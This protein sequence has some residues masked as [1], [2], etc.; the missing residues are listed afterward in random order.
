[1]SIKGKLI[2]VSVLIGLVL[3]VLAALML[4][5]SVRTA[6]QV[7]TAGVDL[8]ELEYLAKTRA[9][10]I[11][12]TKEAMDYLVSGEEQDRADFEAYG[13]GAK[14]SLKSWTEALQ[15]EGDRVHLRK[16]RD[17]EEKYAEFLGLFQ[18]AFAL[19]NAG[20]AAQAVEF[21]RGRAEP[22]LDNVLLERISA[23]MAWEI[24]E[25]GE[26][27]DRVLLKMGLMPWIAEKSRK[28][29][30]IARAAVNYFLVVDRARISITRQMQ[31]AMDYLASAEPQDKKKYEGYGQ[32]AKWSINEWIK[33]I[34]VQIEL[35][36]D[37]E[38]ERE[39][40][41]KVR[42]VDEDYR[43]LLEAVQQAFELREA[44]KV[45]EALDLMEQRVDPVVDG[46]LL[47]EIEEIM[48]D[49]K[50]EVVDAH[51]KLLGFVVSARI[52][53]LTV[54][55]IALGGLFCVAFGM[56]RGMI[57]SLTKLKRGT[58]AIGAGG[59]DHRINLRSRDEF[60]EL[61]ASFNRMAEELQKSRDEIV[62]AKDYTDNILHSM[63]DALVVVLPDGEIQTVNAATCTLLGYE[64]QELL[65]QP[66]G[67]ILGGESPF[68][69]PGSSETAGEW[70][71]RHVETTY[72][73][74]DGWRIP[75]IF[76]SSVMRDTAGEVQG[77]VCVAQ[78]ITER[79]RAEEALRES[80]A[81]FRAL[82]ETAPAAICIYQGERLRYVNPATGAITGYPEKELLQMNVLDL[83][84]PDFREPVRQRNLASR[85]FGS[86]PLRYEI[87]IVT[88]Q[89]R[90]R[91]VD[92]TAA[93]IEFEG[94]PA[95]L[96]T[97]FDITD[98]KVAEERLL[99]DAL[100]DAL[101]GLPNR[102]LF[103][104]R[105]GRAIEWAKRHQDYSFAV[106]FLDLDRFKNVNDSLGHM[107][108]DQLLVEVGRRLEAS[109]NPGD[110]IARLGGDEFVI[111]LEDLKDVS[112][113][114]RMAERIQAELQSPF[115]LGG[116]EVFTTGSIGI[117]FS[118]T[119]YDRAEE[120][121]RD[122]DTAMYRAKML[123]KA[124]YV[125]FDASMHFHAVSLLQL[126]A[127][128]RRAV[129]RREFMVYYQPVVSLS[130]GEVAAVEA[131]VRWRHPQRGLVPPLEF[132]PLAEE[133]GLILPIGEWVLQ[134]AC[135]QT[136][137]WHVAGY[138]RL[139]LMVNFS[140]RQFQD[141]GLLT[142][143]ER[144][145]R[146]TGLPPTALNIEITESV[147]MKDTEYT[148]KML[149]ELDEMGIEISLDDFGTGYSSLGYL[150]RFVIDAIKVDHSFVSNIAGD[151]S[152]VAIVKAIIVMAHSLGLKVVAE[153]VE[154][155]GQ[156]AVLCSLS[157]DQMQG[158]L[159]S[160]PVPAEELTRLLREGR[161]LKTGLKC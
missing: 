143:I 59:L 37:V 132:I 36:Y 110:T 4:W 86:A 120:V 134:T 62:S 151:P 96:A 7:K 78:D 2:T 147:A 32:D 46:V 28:Q 14:D 39:D 65:G 84:H 45:K 29:V 138:P 94:Q 15:A 61:A 71:V 111:L 44:G 23:A 103:M 12:Q 42:G 82:T 91:W 106:L 83:V 53:G 69:N 33:A 50:V 90:E 118:K 156:L 100:H 77:I 58:E 101:T 98:R 117:A 57:V 159:F 11:R 19:R 144:I 22:F 135:S 52:E 8:D 26:G 108:G 136:K 76:S 30:D 113:A 104:D 87:K 48:R 123:G 158:F 126:E 121:L 20:K 79:K 64:A 93:P 97:A 155:K 149:N 43:Q 35:G 140:A 161:H 38:G 81:K 40:L 21:M 148:S 9:A 125:I 129:E 145:L 16:A 154:T 130:S 41:E 54:V 24:E 72:V 127:D 152:Y 47:P 153:G 56:I 6:Q 5:N 31:Q 146:E 160:P 66:L 85:G 74:R 142:M 27:Y 109:L 157:C 137:N 105:L 51:R 70:F 107:A 68:R 55:F 25:I 116:Q 122:A 13:L 92:L 17:I 73:S 3:G 10:I 102:N 128:L 34:K 139:R 80:E 67:K 60:G 150:N 124:R 95:M 99:Y 141:R 18:Q 75:V 131:L 115:N 89:G 133:T 114:V 49:G 119:G 63:N 88:K 1:M 112:D